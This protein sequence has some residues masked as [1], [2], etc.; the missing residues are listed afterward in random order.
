[1]NAQNSVFNEHEVL[2]ELKHY[3]PAQAPLK[4]F[5]HH[6]TLHSFQHLNFHK[7]I[8]KAS[9]M[10]GYRVSLSLAEYR[11]LYQ[12]KKINSDIL[13]RVILE[14]KGP[15]HHQEWKEKVLSTK[16]TKVS[17]LIGNLRSNWKRQ[18]QID[19]DSLVHPILFRILCSYLDQ[20]ISIW[21]FPVKEKSFISSI[22]ELE[23][24]SFTSFFKTKRARNLL[25]RSTAEI[26]D[27]LKILVGDESLFKQYLFD[28]QF[29]HQGWSGMFS[30]IEDQPQTLLE[31][32]K[33][34]IH[35]LIVFELL[36][37][38]DAL[39]SHFGEGWEP[40]ADKVKERPA[41]LFA[42]H[43]K[44]ELDEV[45]TLWQEAFEWTYYD[46]VLAGIKM[47]KPILSTP[48]RK[49]FQAMFCIDDRECSF[50]RYLE[51]FDP[52]C[53]TFGTPGFFGVEFFYQPEDGKFYTK[54]CP[55]P[56][57]PK[58][59][60]K[61]SRLQEK[62]SDGNAL[63]QAYSVVSLGLADLANT[64]ILVSRSVIL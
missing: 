63:Q 43:Q 46:E 5:I 20:G 62:E 27:L 64:G 53:E 32:K 28:Q 6:N 16:Y 45:T 58:Y 30:A 34:S 41:D 61:G 52:C 19:M 47:E 12:A 33:P 22:R 21:N 29:A 11:S 23:R 17:P 39:E 3:L 60:D 51:K 56:V 54:L 26:S 55:A 35:D 14:H 9:A 44:T 38:I 13:D 25:L 50:R 57:T 36:L 48:S 37:E 10:F 2:H 40:L 18:Y 59:L 24:N 8:Y 49:T 1:M 4:D 31:Q 15:D 42:E 7:A